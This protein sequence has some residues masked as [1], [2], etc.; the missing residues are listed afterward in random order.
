ML[1]IRWNESN[2]LGIEIIDEQHRGVVSMFNSI[3][4]IRLMSFDWRYLKIWK[5]SLVVKS[6]M[7]NE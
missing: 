1:Y 3:G 2:D 4:V 7:V 5:V 6:A